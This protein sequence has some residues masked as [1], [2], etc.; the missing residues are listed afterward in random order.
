MRIE[1]TERVF[2]QVGGRQGPAVPEE[3]AF[4]QVRLQPGAVDADGSQHVFRAC[5]DVD[6]DHRDCMDFPDFAP[7]A[8][9]L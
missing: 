3:Q 1:E 8:A 7:S 4:D 9:K 6:A 5:A 2:T